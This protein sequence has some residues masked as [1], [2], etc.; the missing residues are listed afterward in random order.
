VDFSPYGPLT[1]WVKVLM[2]IFKISQYEAIIILGKCH[3][4]KKPLD[5]IEFK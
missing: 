5:T 1:S 4:N 2:G 3:W